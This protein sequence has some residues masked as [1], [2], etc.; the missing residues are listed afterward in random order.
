M[1]LWVAISQGGE[2][3]RAAGQFCPKEV[4]RGLGKWCMNPPVVPDR[5]R[6]CL[7]L[8]IWKTPIIPPKDK[9]GKKKFKKKVSF[10]PVCWGV[11]GEGWLPSL[12]S[13]RHSS[14][15]VYVK[16]KPQINSVRRKWKEFQLCYCHN[17]A[18]TTGWLF[19]P[20][21]FPPLIW[22]VTHATFSNFSLV[23]C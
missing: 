22:A 23:S 13:S 15:C 1:M 9:E 10:K 12:S 18:Q 8:S 17:T 21:S 16:W 5:R 2:P 3:I 6:M 7:F 14:E 4:S 20:S 19:S 11:S